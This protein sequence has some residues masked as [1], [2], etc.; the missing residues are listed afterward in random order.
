MLHAHAW[1]RGRGGRSE[2]L[3][4]KDSGPGLRWWDSGGCSGR[5]SPELKEAWV[6]CWGGL[7][8]LMRSFE[9]HF[10]GEKN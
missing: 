6:L 8:W 1:H 10:M 7:H 9:C 4:I 2:T 5:E 3:W